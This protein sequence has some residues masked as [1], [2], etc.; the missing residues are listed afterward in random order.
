MTRPDHRI[1]RFTDTVDTLGEDLG[2]EWT[3]A[4]TLSDWPLRLT[5][6][7]AKRLVAELEQLGDRYRDQAGAGE[8][9]R[10]LTLQ[11]QVLPL[12]EDDR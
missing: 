1:T 2:Q 4:F 10:P 7:Q 9:A 12:P 3:E 11:V 8:D 6:Q 5:A